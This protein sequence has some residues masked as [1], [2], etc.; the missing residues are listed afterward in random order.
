MSCG[1]GVVAKL[2]LQDDTAVIYEYGGFNWNKP[3]YENR[4]HLMDLLQLL[5]P[6][7]QD[8]KFIKSGKG[9]QAEEKS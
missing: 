5:D 4:A 9:C 6:V 8:R 3:G 7:S 1:I 2:V